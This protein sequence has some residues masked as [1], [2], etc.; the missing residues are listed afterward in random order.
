MKVSND[1]ISGNI[2][3]E[4]NWYSLGHQF[5]E[6]KNDEQAQFLTGIADS[7]MEWENVQIMMQSE[8]ISEDLNKIYH[9]KILKKFLGY[10]EERI[11]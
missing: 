8:Y 11:K 4:I 6:L 5:T 10:L 9:K 2:D 1:A 3:I 7:M